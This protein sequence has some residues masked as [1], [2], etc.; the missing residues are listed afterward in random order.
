MKIEGK[1]GILLVN[2]ENITYVFLDKDYKCIY[3]GVR[4]VKMA[5]SQEGFVLEYDSLGAA[6]YVFDKIILSLGE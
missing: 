2:L 4:D 6:E 5:P 3:V 1:N